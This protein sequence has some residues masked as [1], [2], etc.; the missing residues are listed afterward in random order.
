VDS[1]NVHKL[2][3]S[4]AGVKFYAYGIGSGYHADGTPYSAIEWM[5]YPPL[6]ES[7]TGRS[8]EARVDWMIENLEKQLRLGDNVVDLFGFSRGSASASRFLNAIQAK[9][10]SKDP[11]YIDI[12]IRFVALFDQVPSKASV[13]KQVVSSALDALGHGITISEWQPHPSARNANTI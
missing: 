4:Y 9:I 3:S 5:D 8:M 10:E 1:T 2:Y 6:K 13:T 7:A 11:L 12:E